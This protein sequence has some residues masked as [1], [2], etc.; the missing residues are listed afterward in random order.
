M[1]VRNMTGESGDRGSRKEG[2]NSVRAFEV[3]RKE[4]QVELPA[5]QSYFLSGA[6]EATA[7]ATL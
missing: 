4:G 2:R 5:V 7:H 6:Q 1:L 3:E